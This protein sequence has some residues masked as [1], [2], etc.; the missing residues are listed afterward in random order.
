MRTIKMTIEVRE[1]DN[2]AGAVI[3]GDDKKLE[4]NDLTY[5]ELA[6][7]LDAMAGFYK[8]F[9]RFLKEEQ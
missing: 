4:W 3:T 1:D 8:L 7:M 6:R 9:F 5:E 2:N